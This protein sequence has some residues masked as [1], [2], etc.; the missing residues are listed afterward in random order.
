MGGSSAA[1]AQASERFRQAEEQSAPRTELRCADADAGAIA[2]LVLRIERVDQIDTRGEIAGTAQIERMAD[3]EIDNRVG[4]NV[5]SVRHCAI[6]AQTRSV[7]KIRAEPRRVPFVGKAAGHRQILLMIQMDV[8][9][10]D[11]SKIVRIEAELRGGDVLAFRMLQTGIAV[12][13]KISSGVIRREFQ[14]Y[15]LPCL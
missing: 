8:V 13:R 12:C 3:T 11:V 9:V 15:C 5:I 4:R 14:A 6:L 7:Q 1:H 10:P 2:D